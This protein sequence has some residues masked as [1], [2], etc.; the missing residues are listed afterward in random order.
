MFV[1]KQTGI[2]LDMRFYAGTSEIGWMALRNV[3]ID[4]PRARTDEYE[5]QTEKV[6]HERGPCTKKA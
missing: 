4:D 2:I 5:S 6:Q 3:V 1:D